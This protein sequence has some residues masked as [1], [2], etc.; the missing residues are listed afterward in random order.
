MRSADE[1]GAGGI[2]RRVD[3]DGLGAGAQIGA[4]L[5]GPQLE[6]VRFRHRHVAGHPVHQAHEIRVAGVVG[7]GKEHFVPRVQQPRK[8]E[9]HGGRGARGDDE[10]LRL[11][12]NLIFLQ[13]MLAQGLPELDEPLGVGV[14]GPARGHGPVGR[15]LHHLGGGVVR[16]PD[17]QVDDLLPLA[18]QLLGPLQDVHHQKRGDLPGPAGGALL[19]PVLWLHNIAI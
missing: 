17:L 6:A 19:E 15:V 12:P 18:L 7:V 16:L 8:D 11:D 9:D 2:G 14:L 13:V 10:L 1:Q 3:D 5:L 4:Q